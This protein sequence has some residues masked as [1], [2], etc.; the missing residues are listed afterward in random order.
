[1]EILQN[2]DGFVFRARHLDTEERIWIGSIGSAQVPGSTGR[3]IQQTNMDTQEL[4]LL[5][6]VIIFIGFFGSGGALKC[7]NFRI[8]GSKNSTEYF[9]PCQGFYCG[10][11]YTPGKKTVDRDFQ[12][13]CETQTGYCHWYGL[14]EYEYDT[15]DKK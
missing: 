5:Q 1:M 12:T 6:I 11:V 9:K 3:R 14:T 4:I 10:L 7:E 15:Q 2:L 13:S 8:L